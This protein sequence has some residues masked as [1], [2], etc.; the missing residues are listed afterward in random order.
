MRLSSS[1][2]VFLILLS[3]EPCFAARVNPSLRQQQSVVVAKT[4]NKY[5]PELD[6]A[7]KTL[8]DILRQKQA[9]AARD[10]T[11]KEYCTNHAEELLK[12][13]DEAERK[14]DQE[15]AQL[16]Q[17]EAAKMKCGCCCPHRT[18]LNMEIMYQKRDL[19][20]AEKRV[21]NLK[22]Q[23]KHLQAWCSV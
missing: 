4:R 18:K 10:T 15:Q 21:P 17:L 7:K 13:I 11:K 6:Y 3:V 22:K 19:E 16:D 2:I 12:E 14:L 8:Q 20:Y 23:V 5:D 1:I 9:A